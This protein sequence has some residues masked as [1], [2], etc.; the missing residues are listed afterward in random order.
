MQVLPVL[1]FFYLN[2]LKI[3]DSEECRPLKIHHA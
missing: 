2:N 3:C 1:M